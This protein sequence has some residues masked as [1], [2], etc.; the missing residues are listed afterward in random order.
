MTRADA[1]P[2]PPSLIAALLV[3]AVTAAGLFAV[4][5]SG[6]SYDLVDRQTAALVIWWAVGLGALIVVPGPR[7]PGMAGLLVT[8]FAALIAVWIAVNL[9]HSISKER[10]VAELGRAVTHLGPIVLIGW[11]LPSRYWRDVFGGL[12]VAAVLVLIVALVARLSPGAFG[13]RATVLLPDATSRLSFPFGYWNAIGSW[14]VITALLLLAVSAHAPRRSLRALTLGCLPIATTAGYLTY[15]RSSIGALVIG[16][17]VLVGLSRNRWTTAVHAGLAGVAA[18]L[19]ILVVRSHPA[20]ADGTSG[21]GAPGVVS[22]LALAGLALAVA[23]ACSRPVD[24]ARMPRRLARVVGLTT[25]IAAVV[26][27][28]AL[29][30]AYGDRAWHQFENQRND[31]DVDPAHRLTSLN[32]TRIAQWR[33][34]LHTYEENKLHGTGAGTFELDSNLHATNSEFVRDA[35]N[36]FLEALAEQGWPGLVVLVGLLS[37]ILAAVVVALRRSIVANAT[38][39]RGILAGSAAA[40]AAFT[41][42]TSVD[43]FWEVTALAML[44]VSLAAVVVAAGTDLARTIEGEKASER[45]DTLIDSGARSAQPEA[46]TAVRHVQRRRWPTRAALVVMAIVAILVE[47]PALVGTS[48]V[49][50]SGSDVA[51]GDLVAARAKADQAINTMPWAS[52]PFLQRALVDE[53]AGQWD[54][55]LRA[56]HLAIAR[57]TLDWRLPLVEARIDAK[58]GNA[59][60]ALAAYRKAKSLR[61]MGAFFR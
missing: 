14:A 51:A 53:Q 6:G 49:R 29:T 19:T 61:P 33:I 8:G 24:R 48:D 16:I 59:Q 43:W 3:G 40:L 12:L 34:A 36:A 10:T 9:G 55:A 47:L 13:G 20:I 56:I 45:G 5:F 28:V 52:S 35:H 17:L 57:D 27:G 54:S 41:L 46:A 18:A 37:S 15:S 22:A 1:V 4:G 31:R 26:V 39:E 25:L 23:A 50:K 32:G 11:V 60:G 58:A 44:A 21:S 42:G 7:R 30:S 2:R 38:L